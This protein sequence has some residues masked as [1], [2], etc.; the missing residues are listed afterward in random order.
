MKKTTLIAATLFSLFASLNVYAQ[1]KPVVVPQVTN[2]WHGSISPYLWGVNVNGSL[3]YDQSKL[4]TVSMGTGQLLQ[5]LN[6]GGMLFGELH[7]GNFGVMADLFYAKMTLNKSSVVGQVDLGSKT[8]LE[9][10]IYTLAGT[11]TLHNTSNSYVDALAGVRILSLNA[12]TKI[13][14]ADTPYSA[15]ATMSSTIADPIVG[16]KGRFRIADTDYFV[17]FYADVGGG[18]SSTQVTSQQI[19][20]VGKAYEWGEAT[21][22]FKNLYYKQKSQ[23]SA[24]V[25]LNMYGVLVGATFRF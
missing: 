9:T 22:A 3:Y 1:D 13:S 12:T 14:I 10:G 5:D 20:G 19:L 23:S 16:V 7:K 21:L 8:T 15:V 4:G 6:I 17:P 2:E 11:Y 25:D 18:S 24:T